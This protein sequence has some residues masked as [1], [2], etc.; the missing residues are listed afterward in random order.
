MEVLRFILLCSPS[1]NSHTTISQAPPDLQQI[2][3]T[4]QVALQFTVTADCHPTDI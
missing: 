1:L 2:E 4:K 3:E